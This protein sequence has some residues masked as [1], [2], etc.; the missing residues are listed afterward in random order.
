MPGPWCSSLDSIVT[1]PVWVKYKYRPPF[2]LNLFFHGREHKLSQRD[3]GIS[4]S[5]G[6][7]V[8]KQDLAQPVLLPSSRSFFSFFFFFPTVSRCPNVQGALAPLL[9]PFGVWLKT[10]CGPHYRK[11]FPY[12]FIA[13]PQHSTYN[14]N[15]TIL[16]NGAGD[17]H[18][19]VALQRCAGCRRGPALW[20]TTRSHPIPVLHE[21]F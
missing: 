10:K 8:E 20:V 12:T 3:E 11:C 1:K 13:K 5:Q 9:L 18:S 6:L 15:I 16:P 7:L 4:K 17:H 19:C 14:V 21:A 2:I